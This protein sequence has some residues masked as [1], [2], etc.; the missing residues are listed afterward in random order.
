[1]SEARDRSLL[2][3]LAGELTP[4]EAAALRREAEHDPRLGRRLGELEAIWEGLE[5]APPSA[6]PLGFTGRV[7][8]RAREEIR[9]E[10]R[11]PPT[12]GARAAAALALALG[13]ALGVALGAYRTSPPPGPPASAEW[14]SDAT[15]ADSYWQLLDDPALADPGEEAPR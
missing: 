14:A 5:L 2:R 6:A 8:A 9:D 7:M 4:E 11:L 15:L 1:M 12:L 10:V 13:V 3:L